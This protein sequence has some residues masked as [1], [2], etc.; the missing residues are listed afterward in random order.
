MNALEFLNSEL[1][2][3]GLNFKVYKSGLYK[4]TATASIGFE[5]DGFLH[6]ASIYIS[7]NQEITISWSN[8]SRTNATDALEFARIMQL[9][10]TIASKWEQAVEDKKQNNRALR[11]AIRD[12]A[13]HCNPTQAFLYYLEEIADFPNA[14]SYGEFKAMVET[15]FPVYDQP[16]PLAS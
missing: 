11:W 14:V 3:A 1:K 8:E 4:D 2:E 15:E 16:Q 6:I 13:N 7:D 10:G 5:G 12:Y 9:V